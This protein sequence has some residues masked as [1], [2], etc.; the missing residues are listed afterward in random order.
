MSYGYD[1][2][3]KQAMECV[4]NKLRNPTTRERLTM[5]KKSLEEALKITVDALEALDS[6]PEFERIQ[7]LLMRA[8]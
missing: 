8:L 3:Q 6:S 4:D 1:G 2:S 7:D 5:K